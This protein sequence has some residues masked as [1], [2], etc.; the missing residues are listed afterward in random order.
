MK[1]IKAR[2]KLKLTKQEEKIERDLLENN[3]QLEDGD[4]RDTHIASAKNFRVNLRINDELVEQLKKLAANE[5]LPYQSYINS[6]LY[7]FVKGDLIDKKVFDRVISELKK[8][9]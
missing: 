1:N 4:E 5:H 3:Y 2:N 9:S 8:V 6:I 7:K